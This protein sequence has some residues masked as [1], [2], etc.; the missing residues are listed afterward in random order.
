M[1]HD[2]ANLGRVRTE[3]IADESH[4]PSHRPGNIVMRGTLAHRLAQ[5][6]EREELSAV[7]IRERN[8][9]SA[10]ATRSCADGGLLFLRAPAIDHIEAEAPFRTDPK[11]GQLSS[12]QQSIHGGWMDPQIIRKFPHGKHRGRGGCRA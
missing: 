4:E 10:F 2:G 6:A 9:T 5:P 12:A 3:A 7:R 11:T 1:V 8:S